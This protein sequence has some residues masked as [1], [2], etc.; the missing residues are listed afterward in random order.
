MQKNQGL[1]LKRNK[2]EKTVSMIKEK[3]KVIQ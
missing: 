2:L 1:V 3:S